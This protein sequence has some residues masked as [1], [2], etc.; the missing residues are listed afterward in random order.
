MRASALPGVLGLVT[1][2]ALWLG[3]PAR[4]AAAT[5]D[6][7]RKEQKDCGHCHISDKGAGPRNERG[8]E[9]EANGHRFGIQSWTNAENKAK[10]LRARSALLATWYGESER[11]LAELS[12]EETL[13]GGLALIEGTRKKFS[14]FR[15]AWLRSAEKLLAKGRRGLPNALVFLTKLESQFKGTKEGDRAIE[16]L[17]EMARDEGKRDAVAEARAVEAVRLEYLEGRTE[18][19]L[20]NYERARELLERVARD[21]RG[22]EHTEACREILAEFPGA[23]ESSDTQ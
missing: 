14:M 18:A 4:P 21:P 3:L 7:A 2:A 23:P 17:D 13:P 19:G 15:R 20:A 22:K 6:Y 10:Y 1:A 16:L 11:R 8:K 12:E 5:K 9:Y